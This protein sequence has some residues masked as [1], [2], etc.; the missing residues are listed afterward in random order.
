MVPSHPDADTPG[1]ERAVFDALRDGLSDDWLVLHSRRF[2]LPGGKGAPSEE[3]EIDFLVL[4]P[5]RGLLALEVKGGAVACE[6]GRWTSTER[7]RVHP[8]D[9]PGKQAQRGIHA[10]DRWLLRQRRFATRLPGGMR[11][12][13]FGFGVVLP[14][15][16]VRA[17]LGPSLPRKLVLDGRDLEAPGEALDRVF[18]AHG[19]AGPPLPVGA[20]D[21]FLEAVAPPLRLVR[22]LS[23]QLEQERAAL[24]RLTSEQ[25]RVLESL[26]KTR[27]VAIEG[28]A[29][30]GKTV[31]AVEKARRLAEQGKRV[32]L[33]CFNR[34]LAD[35]LARTA[36]GYDVNT[37]HGLCHDVA[38]R[39]KVPFAIPDE[40]KKA[41][42]FWETEAPVLLLEALEALPDERWDALVVDEGQDFKPHWWEAL[43]HVLREPE[44]GTL[45]VFHD[46][47][48]DLYRGGPPEGFR[49][50]RF[51]LVVNC[52]NTASIARWCAGQIGVEPRVR[53]DAPEGI[54]V[55]EIVCAND[56][57][58]VDAVRRTLHRLLVEERI[59]SENVVVLSTH[60]PQR[61]CL[62]KNRTLGSATLV[63]PEERKKRG[64]VLFTSLQRFKGLE[65][66]FV[67]LCDVVPGEFTSRPVNLYVGGSRARHGP[68]VVR[69]AAPPSGL[70]A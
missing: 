41:Q 58:M 44:K 67:V 2:V 21:A 22:S 69:R 8:I 70:D 35:H 52:R 56:R 23:V 1:S 54:P 34:P 6:G 66:D 55:D 32:L 3:G 30:T 4:D 19:L 29:G 42:A 68:V 20:V 45:Y 13:P 16:I 50:L 57:E 62:A 26:E 18:E 40:P 47:N 65:S 61:S 64:Q 39:A 17:D 12:I 38:E 49:A 36:T 10:L 28:A 5:V 37:F 31:V 25:V 11:R 33:L 24:V 15:T 43:E 7:G 9:D 46:P 59:A 60:T 51:D 27:R 14:H 48:Q 53:P 63:P